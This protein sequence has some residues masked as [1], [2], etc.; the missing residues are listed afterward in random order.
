MCISVLLLECMSDL[1][2]ARP[3]GR[4]RISSVSSLRWRCCH[5]GDRQSVNRLTPPR[6]ERASPT[7]FVALR[8]DGGVYMVSSNVNTSRESEQNS[9]CGTPSSPART[10]TDTIIGRIAAH[11]AAIGKRDRIAVGVENAAARGSSGVAGHVAAIQRQRG[12]VADAAPITG[13]RVARH[14]GGVKGDSVVVIDAAAF[15][16][17]EI[18]RHFT[19]RQCQVAA[20]VKDP[21]AQSRPRAIVADHAARQGDRATCHIAGRIV[22]YAAAPPDAVLPAIV[23]SV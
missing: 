3:N 14:V 19:M 15:A 13:G 16:G 5:G 1:K 17:G 11:G 10:G 23:Q 18:A 20:T 2:T 4:S 22:V 7:P 9:R 6:S 12:E 8:D 21:S